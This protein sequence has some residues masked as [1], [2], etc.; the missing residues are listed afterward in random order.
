MRDHRQWVVSS[1]QRTV[2]PEET[3]SFKGLQQTELSPSKMITLQLSQSLMAKTGM[4]EV[5]LS[6]SSVQW[7]ILN[8]RDSVL[9]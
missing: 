7:K 4:N 1:T 8:K 5:A 6:D 9:R 2:C 3:D